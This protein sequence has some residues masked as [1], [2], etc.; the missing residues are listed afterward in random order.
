MLVPPT[1]ADFMRPSVT[2]PTAHALLRLLCQRTL[3]RLPLPKQI[4]HH[5]LAP[6]FM[7]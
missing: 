3:L 6:Y 7:D 2:Y 5:P 4:L 1:L